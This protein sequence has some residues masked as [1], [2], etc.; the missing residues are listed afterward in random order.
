MFNGTHVC[1]TGWKHIYGFK[2][3]TLDRAWKY[4]KMGLVMVPDI[5]KTRKSRKRDNTC[6]WMDVFF[7]RYGEHMPFKGEIHLPCWFNREK[8]YSM[9]NAELTSRADDFLCYERFCTIWNRNFEHVKIPKVTYN[10]P[11]TKLVIEY[12]LF[13][14]GG[15]K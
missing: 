13:L 12:T 15:D 5:S 4:F 6:A 2:H 14:L 3:G 9:M 7:N 8:V 1:V 10:S 11:E